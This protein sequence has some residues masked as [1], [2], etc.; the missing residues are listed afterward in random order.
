MSHHNITTE[1]QEDGTFV[2]STRLGC[3]KL[4]LVESDTRVDAL[5][6]MIQ[7]LQELKDANDLMLRRAE[8]IFG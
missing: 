6:N 4:I 7:R 8:A 1:A 5:G 2:S 3:R